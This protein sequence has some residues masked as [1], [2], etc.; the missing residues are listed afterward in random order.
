MY[1]AQTGGVI[2]H[3]DESG[4][5][6]VTEQSYDPRPTYRIENARNGRK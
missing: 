2:A 6:A 1:A 5:W 3:I 4:L